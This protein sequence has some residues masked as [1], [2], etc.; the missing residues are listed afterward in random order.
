MCVLV[1]RVAVAMLLLAVIGLAVWV[2]VYNVRV[3]KASLELKKENEVTLTKADPNATDDSSQGAKLVGKAAP[4]FTLKDLSGKTVSLADFKGHPVVVN[5][6]ATWCGPCKLEMPWFEQM[7]Q[8]YKGDGLVV[9]GLSQDD[10]TGADEIA[11]AVKKI[12]VSYPIL[13]PDSATP[14]AYGGVDYLPE[15]FY[16]DAKGTVV[17]TTAGAP[18]K[19]QIEA[20]VEKTI[21]SK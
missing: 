1:R 5:F 11:K 18:T 4:A 16:V 2:G 8:K 21:A 20:L 3:R 17:E 12:G 14:K 7:Y 15:T 9:L 6:W 10:G 13:M 19:D